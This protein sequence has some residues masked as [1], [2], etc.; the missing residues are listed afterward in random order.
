MK[1]VQLRSYFWSV[2][3]RIRTECGEIRSGVLSKKVQSLQAHFTNLK[4]SKN[5]FPRKSSI[6][7]AIQ[8]T[9]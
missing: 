8:F 3:S 7:K 4:K 9:R 6:D 1:S 2:F 5:N